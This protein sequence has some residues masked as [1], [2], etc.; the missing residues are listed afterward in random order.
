MQDDQWKLTSASKPLIF[1][2]SKI[3]MLITDIRQ[4]LLLQIHT[5]NNWMV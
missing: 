5:P 2:G 3:F 4:L 1:G